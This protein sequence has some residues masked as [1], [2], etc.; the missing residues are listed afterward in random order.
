MNDRPRRLL[1]ELADGFDNGCCKLSSTEW[2]SANNV[3]LDECQTLSDAIA[4]AVR[5]WANANQRWKLVLSALSL[6]QSE[7]DGSAMADVALLNATQKR[8]RKQ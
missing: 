3:T 2:L 6:G 8:L 4:V 1:R 5:A 7:V